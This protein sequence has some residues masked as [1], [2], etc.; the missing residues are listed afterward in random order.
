VAIVASRMK[1]NVYERRK[2][3]SKELVEGGAI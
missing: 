3:K 2:S 1:V